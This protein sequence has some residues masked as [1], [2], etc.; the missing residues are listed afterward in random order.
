MDCHRPS[1]PLPALLLPLRSECLQPVLTNS[2]LGGERSGSDVEIG[3]RVAAGEFAGEDGLSKVALDLENL[4]A[5]LRLS[6][7]LED[8]SWIRL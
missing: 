7:K 3:R 2:R 5:A 4:G 1:L 6:A 8:E